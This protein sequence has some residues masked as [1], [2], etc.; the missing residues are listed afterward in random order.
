MPCG[1]RGEVGD[2][3]DGQQGIVEGSHSQDHS[4][5]DFVDYGRCFARLG[6][7]FTKVY[8][9]VQFGLNLEDRESDD[10]HDEDVECARFPCSFADKSH[11][12]GTAQIL[13][14]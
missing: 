5:K 4:Q 8:N 12:I 9:V 13:A 1:Y 14:S 3:K 2:G 11:L 6:E 7:P 10:E